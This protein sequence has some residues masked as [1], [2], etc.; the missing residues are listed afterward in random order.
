M[1]DL[2]A[3]YKTIDELSPEELKRLF[4]YI[5]SKNAQITAD[6]PS[7]KPRIIGLHEHLGH[8]W[9]SEDFNDP[10]P[11]EFWLGEE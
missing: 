10:L 3:L 6:E 2:E 11:E 1:I 4:K 8:A 7:S 9:M 5:E